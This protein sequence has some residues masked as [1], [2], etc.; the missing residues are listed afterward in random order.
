M[1]NQLYVSGMGAPNRLCDKDGNWHILRNTPHM[2]KDVNLVENKPV[3]FNC[4]KPDMPLPE[5]Q[6][7][8]LYTILLT[9][10][11]GKFFAPWWVYVNDG[12]SLFLFIL[13]ISGIIRWYRKKN[14]FI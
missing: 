3:Y 8:T 10:H 11:D 4:G 7:T 12:A 13:F 1:G 9:L 2:F 6:T 5:L 14:K